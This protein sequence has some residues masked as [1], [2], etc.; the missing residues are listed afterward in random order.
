[1]AVRERSLLG[2]SNPK[3]PE[4]DSSQERVSKSRISVS[5]RPGIVVVRTVSSNPGTVRLRVRKAIKE[6]VSSSRTRRRLIDIV[7]EVGNA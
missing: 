5:D 6:S 2:P 7:D 1:M 3:E 4:K